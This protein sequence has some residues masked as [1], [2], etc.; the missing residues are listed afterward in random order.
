VRRLTLNGF[1]EREL[2]H[3]VIVAATG[4][5][6]IQPQGRYL[7]GEDPRVLTQRQLEAKINFCDLDLPKVRR[8]VMIQCV[9]S[10]EPD[11]PYCSRLCCSQALKNALL[12]KERYPLMEI[13]I[14]YRDLRAYGFRENY[15]VEAKERGVTFIPFEAAQPPQVIAA[16][17]RP[18][19]VRV[20]DELLGQEMALAADLVVLSTGIE[21]AAGSEQ[22]A[23]QLRIPQTLDGW[24]Q[25]AHQKLRPVD[26]ATEGV[27]L[28]G[29]AHYPKSLGET[30]AQA[31]AAAMRAAGILFQTELV[32]SEL[33][34]MITPEACRRCLAC[35]ELC[36]FGAVALAD[37]KPEV[38]LEV[39]RGCGVCAA[40]CPAG[41]IHMSRITEM[42]LTA[43]I[44]AALG[45]ERSVGGD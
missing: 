41:A 7:S 45:G 42:E 21:P 8:L 43:Q 11:H 10:R 44:E 13:T 30:A 29:V 31:Q 3:G 12:L 32:A 17:R 22:V 16:R 36:P 6:E 27:F 23:R 25:E 24:F 14:L 35:L 37:G 33:V 1:Q 4:G 15:Y 20:A 39:C 34:A 40:E 9:G 5:R 26:S 18:L 38:H 19:T 2:L 28:C